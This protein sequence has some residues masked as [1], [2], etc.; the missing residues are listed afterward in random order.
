MADNLRWIRQPI[1]S[2]NPANGEILA[3]LPCATDA[4]VLAVVECARRAQPA[5]EAF[6][7][8][9]RVRIL[10]RFQQLLQERKREVARL[11]TL[12]AGKPYVESLTT[13]ILLVLDAVRFCTKNVSC[14]SPRREAPA[15]KSDDEGQT[16]ALDS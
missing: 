2:R 3:E 13:E 6:G 1:I 11:I 15:R 14:V 4:D 10:R 8:P 5:W 9:Q 16:W 12:E 7:I